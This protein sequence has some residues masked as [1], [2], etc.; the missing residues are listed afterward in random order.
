MTN[1]AR[2]LNGIDLKK[3]TMKA[4]TL[5]AMIMLVGYRIFMDYKGRLTTPLVGLFL[6]L[7]GSNLKRKGRKTHTILATS[8]P[9]GVLKKNHLKK[10]EEHEFA[11]L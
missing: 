9:F 6:L 2:L 3:K 11:C 10:R 4:P 1:I 8:I 5:D 7:D